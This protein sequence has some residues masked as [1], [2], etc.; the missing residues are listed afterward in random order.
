MLFYNTNVI[1]NDLEFIVNTNLNYEKF[2]NKTVL[3]TGINGMI[4]TNLTFLFMYLNDNLNYNISVI[5]LGRNKSEFKSRFGE[6]SKKISFIE[7]DVNDEIKIKQKVD[8]IF[9]AATNASPENMV[10]HPVSIAMVNTLGTINVAKFAL[11][12][13]AHLHFLSTREI[14]GYSSNNEILEDDVSILNSIDIRNVYPISK[15]SAESILLAFKEE[16]NLSISISRIAHAYGPGMKLQN[17]GR[18]M[19]DF[20]GKTIKNENIIL[21]SDGTAE[22]AFIYTRD[23]ILGILF[24][25]LEHSE[26]NFT[27]NLSNEQEP[28]MVKD[29]AYLI[30]NC[31][32]LFGLNNEV[33]FLSDQSV[34]G[35]SKI[36]RTP[37]STKKLRSLGWSPTVSLENGINSTLNV[38]NELKE[39]KY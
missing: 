37:L 3:I 9:H 24:I 16:Y 7:Q 27:F 36:I 5:G 23:A 1:Q 11:K 14:Y 39:I 15:M 33:I 18:V 8:Y 28:I 20:L 25:V 17:D 6:E 2:R 21:N 10:D 35:Y 26:G 4:A 31:G 38:Y 19:A 13:N 29:L 32:K 12:N 22:R 34:Q 30:K